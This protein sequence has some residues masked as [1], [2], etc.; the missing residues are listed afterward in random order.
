LPTVQDLSGQN[1]KVLYAT[2]TPVVEDAPVHKKGKKNSKNHK[3]G[4]A[5]KS[6]A[7]KQQDV[8]NHAMEV[9]EQKFINKAVTSKKTHS[10]VH[11]ENLAIKAALRHSN[12]P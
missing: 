6:D 7:E 9:K 8:L 1:E 4:V 11:K 3:K 2:S 5:F 12:V 10:P